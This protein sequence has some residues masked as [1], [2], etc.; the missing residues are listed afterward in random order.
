M[1][2]QVIV[3]IELENGKT[4]SHYSSLRIKQ[5]LFKHHQFKLVVPFEVLENTDERFFN[6]SHQDVCGK[7][8]TIS[9]DSEYDKDAKSKFS[10][11]FK[12][13]ITEI[14]LH[15]EG[16][17]SNVFVIKGY[18]PTILLEDLNIK[19]TFFDHTLNSIFSSVLGVYAVNLLKTKLQ[20]KASSSIKYTVQYNET[21]FAFLSRLAAEYGEW[22]FYNGQELQLG[23]GNSN[24]VNFK[25]DGIQS[26]EMSIS[27]KPLKFEISRYD[28]TNDDTYSVDVSNQSIDGLNEYGNFAMNTSASIFDNKSFI[29]SKKAVYNHGDLDDLAKLQNAVNGTE[30]VT[31]YGKGEVPDITIGT[32]VNVQ[33]SVPEKGGRAKD[34]AFGKYMAIEITHKVDGSGNYSNEFKAVPESIN[35]PPPNPYVTHPVGETELAKVVDNDDPDGMGR[36]KVSFLWPGGDDISKTSD[37][38]RVGTFYNGVASKGMFFIPEIGTQVLV[39][40]ELN[41]PE[42]PFVITSVYPNEGSIRKIEKDNTRKYIYTQSGNQI[43]F[44]DDESTNKIEI[45][46]ENSDTIISLSFESPGVISIKTGGNIELQASDS[47]K[48]KADKKISM[49]APEVEIKAQQSLSA[50]GGTKAEIKAA[51]VNVEADANATF[52]GGAQAKVTS[53]LTEVSAD[54]V[55]TVKGALVKIN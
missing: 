47:I 16:N 40:Y 28:Y 55:M 48:L 54:G 19:R 18:S 49:E 10:Y 2:Q 15:N 39:D 36:V 46:N 32:V 17:L 30:L 51:Q 22:F 25:I 41:H 8:I 21:N 27:L 4:I 7:K 35:Y 14:S 24:E 12:G 11:I 20:P 42:Y 13:I 50:D 53:P 3:K 5:S 31:F 33:G 6:T 45:T 44:Y 29:T 26:F 34:H 38:I 43:V 1:A 37:W 9:F 23:K 52:K